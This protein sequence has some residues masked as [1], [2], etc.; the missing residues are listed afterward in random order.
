MN[1]ETWYVM[2]DGSVT[3]PREVAR[4]AKGILHTKDGRAV[5]MRGDV[6]RSRS[7]DVDLIVKAQAAR[8]ADAASK[9][10]TA[11]ASPVA[12]DIKPEVK[13]DSAAPGYKT[14]ESKA[15]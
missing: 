9:K 12:K 1:R 7:V 15:D 8:A 4:D 3:H 10:K 6:P 14:R 2:E 5:A 11:D 13:P